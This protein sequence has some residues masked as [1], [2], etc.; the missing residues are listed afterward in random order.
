MIQLS[1]D[2]VLISKRTSSSDTLLNGIVE[3]D[4]SFDPASSVLI[5]F[6]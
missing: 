6:A 4:N 3:N 1:K 2:H 5:A